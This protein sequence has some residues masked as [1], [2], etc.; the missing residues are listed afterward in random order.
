MLLLGWVARSINAVELNLACPNIPGKP[1]VAYDFEQVR[2]SSFRS[3][4]KL[5]L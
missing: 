4:V 2:L 3:G 1:T 5:R